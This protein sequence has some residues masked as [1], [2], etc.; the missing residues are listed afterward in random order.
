MNVVQTEN[1]LTGHSDYLCEDGTDTNQIAGYW[2]LCSVNKGGT[3]KLRARSNAAFHLQFFRLGWYGGL[4]ARKIGSSIAITAQTQPN[5][6]IVMDEEGNT[7][8]YVEC[9]WADSYSLTVP[10]EWVSGVYLGKMTRDTDSRQAL[11]I[12][13]VR[14][15]S[16]TGADI[17]CSLDEFTWQNYNDWGPNAG[18][19]STYN[20]QEPPFTE[21]G[22]R[23]SFDRPYAMA[24]VNAYDPGTGPIST[25]AWDRSIV[26]SGRIFGDEAN[27]SKITAGHAA[28]MWLEKEGYDVRYCSQM[29]RATNPTMMLQP[30]VLFTAGHDEYWTLE[31]MESVQ[32]RLDAG[33]HCMELSGNTAYWMVRVEQSSLGVS[34]RR[35][36]SFKTACASDTE[37]PTLE[38][39]TGYM[40][41]RVLSGDSTE[42]PPTSTVSTNPPEESIIGL[43]WAQGGPGQVDTPYGLDCY[44]ANHTNKAWTGAGITG[45]SNASVTLGQTI[46]NLVGHEWDCSWEGNN[47]EAKFNVS[48]HA[49]Q[50]L[51]TFPN[52][53]TTNRRQGMAPP[54]PFTSLL[55]MTHRDVATNSNQLFDAGYYQRTDNDAIMFNGGCD[56]F[57]L[58]LAQPPHITTGLGFASRESTPIKV[59]IGNVFR[60]M[61]VVPGAVGASREL[62]VEIDPVGGGSW[63]MYADWSSDLNPP[64]PATYPAGTTGA[65]AK[66]RDTANHAHVGPWATISRDLVD[67]AAAEGARYYATTI[68]GRRYHA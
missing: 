43:Q 65:R 61:G 47:L 57:A 56:W 68:L 22:H 4:G 41:G 59:M 62:Y 46:G 17:L 21:E 26:G 67:P 38:Q 9:A 58:A 29:D 54:D 45:G 63:E 32:A 55:V 52:G 35:I 34:N 20:W 27:A 19:R 31:E 53:L 66:F 6:E 40:A 7:Q 30:R 44:V 51:T 18:R 64:A 14:D 42:P 48:T 10:D 60:M 39:R 5:D 49:G 11:S 50:L 23:V 2:S 25:T 8:S 3:I 28:I 24:R 15:D 33:K 37:A 1:A 12:F 16:R 36:A 13:V